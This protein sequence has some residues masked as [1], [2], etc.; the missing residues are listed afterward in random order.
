MQIVTTRC[1]HKN[2]RE[3]AKLTGLQHDAFISLVRNLQAHHNKRNHLHFKSLLPPS[4]NLY[5]SG[6]TLPS[7]SSLHNIPLYNLARMVVERT[8]GLRGKQLGE[9]MKEPNKW[10]KGYGQIITEEGARVR[11]YNE[12]GGR[13]E[14]E[15]EE[16]EEEGD[17][18]PF[19]EVDGE[20]EGGSEG[21]VPF[22]PLY[23]DVIKAVSLDP[24]NGPLHDAYRRQQGIEY[25][26]LLTRQ[27]LSLGASFKTEEDLRESGK[28]KTPDVV[29]EVPVGIKV[30][31]KWRGVRWI[32]SKAMYGDEGTNKHEVR[33]QA[34]GY[35]HRYG[36]GAVVYWFGWG[37]EEPK[38]E[39]GWVWVGGGLPEI[40]VL[41][42]GGVL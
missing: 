9:A 17:W 36:Q 34:E 35:V 40:K 15:E 8:T 11:R 25:E 5:L 7:I 32:D 31:G 4:L 30:G 26:A 18:D 22:Y 29:L 6:R 39:E 24:I 19:R 33:R 12:I 10:L 41:P 20:E 21:G 3:G 37:G 23:K 13:G 16:E 42:D 1:T 38:E 27:L 28:S 2:I 14:R